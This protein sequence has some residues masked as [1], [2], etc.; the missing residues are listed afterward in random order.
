MK[1]KHACSSEARAFRQGPRF[2]VQPSEPDASASQPSPPT[3][4]RGTHPGC[5]FPLLTLDELAAH[6]RLSQRTIRRLVAA[7]RLP[8]VRIGRQLRF[9]PADVFRFVSARKD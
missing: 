8:C 4:G 9:D 6:L 1:P 3:N 7:R 5:A 2:N